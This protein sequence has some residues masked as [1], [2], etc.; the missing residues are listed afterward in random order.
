MKVYCAGP[1]FNQGEKDEMA[2]IASTIEECSHTTFLPQRDGLELSKGAMPYDI[3]CLDTYEVLVDCDMVVANLNGRV[4]D[5]GT[6]AEA[7]MAFGN[8]RY[9]I[10]YKSDSRT[11]FQ[12]Q[13]NPLV[14]FLGYYHVSSLDE[15]RTA[16]IRTMQFNYAGLIQD[17]L[18]Y[19]K[20]LAMGKVK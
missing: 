7:A 17:R 15:L 9:V 8:S 14:T 4:P 13:D 12:G 16:L 2:K 3:F 18:E 5:E 11:V 6:V 1:F 19:G 20:K 10:L